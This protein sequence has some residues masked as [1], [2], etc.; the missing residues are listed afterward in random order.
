[1]ENKEVLLVSSYSRFIEKDDSFNDNT[2]LGLGVFAAKTE[3][4]KLS[5]KLGDGQTTYE[6]LP[7][8]SGIGGSFVD[9]ADATVE[10]L[11][12]TSDLNLAGDFAIGNLVATT[13][14]ADAIKINGQNLNELL[15]EQILKTDW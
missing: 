7:E 4:G 13:I 10:N 5:L 3:E 14:D 8:V 15:A 11:T 9:G 6:N 2:I 1:M 12:V